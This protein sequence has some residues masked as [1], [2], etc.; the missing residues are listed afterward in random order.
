MKFRSISFWGLFKI[1]LILDF[2]I[3]I[4]ITP[5]FAVYYFIAPDK[6]EINLDNDF[7]LYGLSFDVT[8]GDG[9]IS[10]A[11]ILI[12][13]IGIIGLLAQCG[14]LYFLAQKTPLGNVTVGRL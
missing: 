6:F 7:N 14:I 4:L 10:A 9:S 11:I 1:S 5:F 3:P 2:V 12:I 8:S 13:L